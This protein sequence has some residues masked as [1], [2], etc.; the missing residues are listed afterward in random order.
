MHIYILMQKEWSIIQA[1]GRAKL[2]L[3]EKQMLL[4]IITVRK[5][6]QTQKE[7]YR[8]FSHMSRLK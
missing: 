3:V 1:Q 4:K 5:I 8:V 7:K 6:N 2:S